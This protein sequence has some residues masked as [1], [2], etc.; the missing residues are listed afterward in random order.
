MTPDPTGAIDPSAPLPALR[1]LEAFPVEHEGRQ[2]IGLRDPLAIASGVLLVAMPV[3]YLAAQLDGQST[4]RDLQADFA[5]RFGQIVA[6][7]QVAVLVR[8]L[9]EALLLAT[10]R[11]EEAFAAVRRAFDEAAVRPAFHAGLC[12]PA[13]EAEALAAIDA[14]FTHPRGPG[15]LAAV[16]GAAAGP[17]AG[18]VFAPHYDPRRGGFLLAQAFARVAQ[19]GLLERVVVLGTNHQPSTALF[20]A[21][22]K[23]FATPFGVVRAE[24]C[25]LEVLAARYPGDLFAEEFCHRREHSIEFQVVMLAYVWKKLG[26]G[27]PPPVVPILVG[28]FHEF[29]GGE[30]VDDGR[31]RAIAEGLAAV[32]VEGA[33]RT[34]LVASGDLAHVGPRFGDEAPMDAAFLAAVEEDDRAVMAA[35]AA[36]SAAGFHRTIARHEDRRRMCGHSC[37]YMLM[38]A[39]EAM[40]PSAYRGAVLGYEMARDPDGAVSYCAVAFSR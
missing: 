27:E 12:F 19:A 9:D 29:Y 15:P 23:A 24:E 25:A 6:A 16:A 32:A 26:R 8:Q 7:E 37:G 30:P 22:R 2:L 10:P 20:T 35:M 31:V 38:R 34:L 1:A 11:F 3:Y 13:A 28:S 21:T 18:A 17:P 5:S 33:G 40:D 39:Y 36:G 14:Y 4:T